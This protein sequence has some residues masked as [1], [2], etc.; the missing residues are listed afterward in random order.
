MT[1]IALSVGSGLLYAAAEPPRAVSWLAVIALVPLLA[2]VRGRSAP[3]RFLLGWAAGT[4]ACSLLTSS[5]IY[6]AVDRFFDVPEIARWVAAFLIPQAYG[7]PWFGVFAV[8]AGPALN[9]DRTIARPLVVVPAA[10]VACEFARA[11]LGHGLP[12][13]LLAHSQIANPLMLQPAAW[14]GV[15]A[16]SF[17]L[18]FSNVT[19]LTAIQSLAGA[20]D[21]PVAF[22]R[23]GTAAVVLAV[24]L[25]WASYERSWWEHHEG[26]QAA[27]VALVQAAVPASWGGQLAR[28]PEIVRRLTERTTAAA[29]H[30]PQLVVWPE[31]ALGFLAEANPRRLETLGG[32]L[33]TDSQLLL[34][35][36]RVSTP[37]GGATEFRNSALLL[38]QDGRVRSAYSKV[39]LTPFAEYWPALLP[40]RPVGGSD[41]YVPGQDSA[42]LDSAGGRLGVLICSEGFYPDLAISRVRDGAQILVNLANDAWFGGTPAL[43]QHF[44]ATAIRAVETRRFLLRSSNMGMT[45]IVSPWGETIASDPGLEPS[46]VV[47]D[48]HRQDGLSLYVRFGDWF[49]W[50]CVLLAALDTAIG[51]YRRDP[52]G[53]LDGGK[54]LSDGDR[55]SELNT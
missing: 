30:R 11:S 55:S 49:A 50:A 12:W 17:L 33:S 18:C 39:R 42:P 24:G 34:G 47:S 23:M 29:A 20:L 31:N 40:G 35:S 37:T 9:D 26:D 8:A 21:R 45:A 4:V 48:I 7:A 10:W 28:G 13:V 19:T 27:S 43:E 16:V 44:A 36:P 22:R 1:S 54:R 53:R 52:N 15:Y 32:L 25:G 51:S 6:V 2:A 3:Q 5:S 46:I 14:G 38:G 41:A